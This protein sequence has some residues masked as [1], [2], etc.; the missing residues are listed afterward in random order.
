MRR[1]ILKGVLPL[2]K[3]GEGLRGRADSLELELYFTDGAG[4]EGPSGYRARALPVRTYEEGGRLRVKRYACMR[5]ADVLILPAERMTKD[6]TAYAAAEYAARAM[7]LV[8]EAVRR[9]GLAGPDWRRALL[10]GGRPW[11]EGCP[12]SAL[13]DGRA[14]PRGTERAAV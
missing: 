7:S 9:N 6:A 12:I 3:G 10:R 2:K 4:F 11:K 8:E 13:A 5:E 1:R 14:Y